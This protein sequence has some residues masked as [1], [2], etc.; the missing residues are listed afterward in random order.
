MNKTQKK[1]AKA[2]I[3]LRGKKYFIPKTIEE[4]AEF[5]QALAK[6][7]NDPK[8]L[9]DPNLFEEMGQVKAFIEILEEFIFVRPLEKKAIKQSYKEKFEIFLAKIKDSKC[10]QPT[11]S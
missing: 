5:T 4:M 9:Q 6:G 8:A 10:E 1:I 11:K 3:K 7:I 2:Y